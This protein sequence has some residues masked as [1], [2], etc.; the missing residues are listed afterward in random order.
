MALCGRGTIYDD[1]ELMMNDA[2]AVSLSFLQCFDLRL[3][4]LIS[5]VS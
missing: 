4:F 1:D 2:E 5:N 3:E